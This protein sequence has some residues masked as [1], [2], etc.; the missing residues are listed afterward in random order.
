MITREQFEQLEALDAGNNLVLSTYLDLDP[1]RQ[2]R[3][4]YRIVFEDLTK[5]ARKPLDE[6]QRAALTSEAA[7]VQT[8]LKPAQPHE[9]GLALFA[10]EPLGLWQVYFFQ[11][12]M[13]DYL[14]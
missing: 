6:S 1:E 13:R 8:C 5:D 3:R 14:A 2:V 12:P 11:V 4:A 9:K 10:C 7:R